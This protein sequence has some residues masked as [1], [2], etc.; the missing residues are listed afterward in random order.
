MKRCFH[1]I[2]EKNLTFFHLVQSWFLL[3]TIYQRLFLKLGQVFFIWGMKIDRSHITWVRRLFEINF[4]QNL[5]TC[6]SSWEAAEVSESGPSSNSR[7]DIFVTKTTQLCQDVILK[8]KKFCLIFL[9]FEIQAIIKLC[10][11]RCRSITKFKG[12]QNNDNIFN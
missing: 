12:C 6:S 4:E 2:F 1:E 3:G 8:H 11:L 5:P 10:L 7:E 9:C